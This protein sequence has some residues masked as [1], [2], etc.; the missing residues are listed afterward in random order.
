MN[1]E[2]RLGFLESKV[3]EFESKVKEFEQNIGTTRKVDWNLKWNFKWRK[4]V[5]TIFIMALGNFLSHL[6]PEP[7]FT[8]KAILAASTTA[9]G[10]LA[11]YYGLNVAPYSLHK[12]ASGGSEATVS[13]SA[14]ENGKNCL[15]DRDGLSR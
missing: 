8:I 2:E 12:T 11:L 1:I 9:I 5:I 10:A 13:V 7:F 3:K 4:Y 14:E 15:F 6:S